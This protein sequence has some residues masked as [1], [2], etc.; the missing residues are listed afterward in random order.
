MCVGKER[1]CTRGYVWSAYP[2]GVI[3][4]NKKNIRNLSVQVCEFVCSICCTIRCKPV[5]LQ[6]LQVQNLRPAARRWKSELTK[7]EIAK[8]VACR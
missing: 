4:K 6:L 8:R 3:H 5:G 7:L 2:N 1:E